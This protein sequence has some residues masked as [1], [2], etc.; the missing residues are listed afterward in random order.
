MFVPSNYYLG[1][2][3]LPYDPKNPD[4][5]QNILRLAQ[6]NP[7]HPEVQKYRQLVAGGTLQTE[8]LQA[9][10]VELPDG[11]E[12]SDDDYVEEMLKLADLDDPESEPTYK[13]NDEICRAFA[14]GKI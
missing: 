7:K 14:D 13:D 3:Y 12:Q 4:Y 11:L 8:D 9:D 2:G 6:K 1:G 10:G 5:E